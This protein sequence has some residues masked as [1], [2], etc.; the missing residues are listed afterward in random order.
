MMHFYQIEN[1]VSFISGVKN[2]VDPALTAAS[3]N[4]LGEFSGLKS[5][6]NFASDD[7]VSLFQDILIDL[8]VGEYFR[9]FIDSIITYIGQNENG[10]APAFGDRE[11]RVTV[12]SI[13]Q[14]INDYSSNDITVFLKKIWLA[15]YHR[16]IM[17]NCNGTTQEYMD[18]LLKSESDWATLQ[19]IYNSFNKREMSDSKGQGLRKKYFNNLGHLYPGRTN[20]LNDSKEYKDLVDRLEGSEYHQ[21]FTRIPDPVKADQEPEVDMALTIDDCQKRD[22]SHRYSM[23][24]MGQF[25]YAVFYSYLKLKE[26]EIQNIVQLAEIFSID[27]LPKNHPAWK[28][29]VPPFQYDIDNKGA[30]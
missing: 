4:P 13:S 18:D 14:M 25:Q 24:F 28:K 22:L 23:G 26:L 12:E 21:Y 29:Y 15:Q 10:G 1:V 30:E 27:G 6:G 11:E 2:N 5:V 7:F 3:L 17:Q 9:K 20:K 19:I 8:P 16:W